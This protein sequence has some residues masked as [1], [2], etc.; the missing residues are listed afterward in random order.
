MLR[1]KVSSSS[2]CWIFVMLSIFTIPAFSSSVLSADSTYT[3]SGGIAALTNQTFISSVKNKSAVTVTN[4]GT[5]TLTNSTITT[6]GNTSSEDSSNFYG[7]NAAVLAKTASKITMTGCSITTSGTGA[8]GVF[9]TGSGTEIILT[10]D[11]I[12]CTGTSGHGVDA[13]IAGKLT[14]TDV[15]IT[16]TKAHGAAYATDRGG[17]TINVTRGVATTSGQDSPAIY[18][19]GTITLSGG[20]ATA[21]NSEAAVIEGKNYITL[22]GTALSGAKGTRDWGVM[23]YQSMSGDAEGDTGYFA[24]T[25]GSYT[26]PS[27]TGPAFYVTN[28]TGIITL[29]D[30]TVNNSSGTLLK[31]AAGSWGTSGSNEGIIKFTADGVSLT[32][33]MIC[34]AISSITATFKNSSSLTGAIDSAALSLDATSSWTVTATSYL[35]TFSDPDG[36]SGTS[37]KNITGNGNYVYYNADL[38]GNS[39]LG[40]LTYSLVN[41]GYLL[42]TGTVPQTDCCVTRVGDANGSGNDEPTIGDI[43]SM[44]DAKFITGACSGVISCLA[45][46]DINQSGGSSPTCDDITVGDVSALIDYLFI[47]GPDA[48]TLPDCF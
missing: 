2:V 20:V 1:D 15:I 25:G 8:N 16:T 30:V 35:T 24:M 22:T 40:G 29:T 10:N 11:T 31:A 21:T 13:T 5:L 19:T 34:D 48:G 3:Q 23:I 33:S 45:E 9:S 4:S 27:T 46:A 12:V 47:T 7:L 43:S 36:I 37:V 42:P 6:S 17:G 41:G 39:A 18:S 38:S 44:I 26:W 28:G 14:L 32:G